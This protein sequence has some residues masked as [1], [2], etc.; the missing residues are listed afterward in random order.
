[1]EQRTKCDWRGNLGIYL[2]QFLIIIGLGIFLNWFINVTYLTLEQKEQIHILHS[3]LNYIFLPMLIIFDIF[4][5]KETTFVISPTRIEIHNTFLGYKRNI[6][7]LDS[8]HDIT[9]LSGSFEKYFGLS[10]IIL[11]SREK[12]HC[13]GPALFSQE[14]INQ[15]IEQVYK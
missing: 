15:L 4:Y 9:I 3:F 13:I 8:V 7:Y 2:F 12:I 10:S 6:I 11:Y 14:I 5:D 1:M